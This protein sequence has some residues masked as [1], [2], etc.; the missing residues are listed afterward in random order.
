MGRMGE[1]SIR[2]VHALEGGGVVAASGSRAE[3]PWGVSKFVSGAL[4]ES[5]LVEKG[6]LGMRADFL[7]FFWMHTLLSPPQPSV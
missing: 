2:L 1:M 5:G 4:A 6:F 7:S 3:E